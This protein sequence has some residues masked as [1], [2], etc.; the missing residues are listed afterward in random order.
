MAAVDYRNPQNMLSKSSENKETPVSDTSAFQNFYD[1]FFRDYGFLSRSQYLFCFLT[2]LTILPLLVL[3]LIKN[4]GYIASVSPK[5]HTF[6]FIILLALICSYIV[7]YYIENF[8]V[9]IIL[10]VLV[11]LILFV[12]ILIFII[13]TFSRIAAK[14]FADTGCAN[15]PISSFVLLFVLGFIGTLINFFFLLLTSSSE[16][17]PVHSKH[18]VIIS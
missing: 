6:K 7:G 12:K 9:A 18:T 3:K 10:G 17:K 5:Q 15:Y 4:K 14:R 2:G 8:A 11:G 13:T 1:L 16:N